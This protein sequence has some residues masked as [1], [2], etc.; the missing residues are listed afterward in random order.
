MLTLEP[1][2]FGGQTGHI[3]LARDVTAAASTARGDASALGASVGVFR[4]VAARRGVFVD[5]SPAARE[6]LALVSVEEGGQLALADCFAGPDEYGRVYR[7]LL[8]TGEVR[9]Q[10]LSIET[11]TGPRSV[12]LSGVLVRDEEDE[13]AWIDGLMVDVTAAR[14]GA[15]DREVQQLRASLLFLHEPIEAL[16]VDPHR[17]AHGGAARGRWPRP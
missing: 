13:P 9:D 7:R 5:L 6:L 10:F 11:A 1:V 17:G 2:E 15:A 14:G 4:A 3:L 12:L 16:G 8:E